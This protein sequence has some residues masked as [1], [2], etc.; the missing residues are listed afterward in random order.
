MSFILGLFV[1]VT[2]FILGFIFGGYISYRLSFDD[3]VDDVFVE[4]DETSL[5]GETVTVVLDNFGDLVD[6]V[7]DCHK[8]NVPFG[9]LIKTRNGSLF[10]IIFQDKTMHLDRCFNMD[11]EG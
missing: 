3:E 11:N 9:T 5:D 7:L 6:V 2:I 10:R 8:N 1:G 4:D